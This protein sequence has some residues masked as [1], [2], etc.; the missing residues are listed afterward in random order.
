MPQGQP[1]QL[2]QALAQQDN[3]VQDEGSLDPLA[4][5]QD[6]IHALLGAQFAEGDGQNVH[7]LS[8]AM[9]LL[10]G[11]QARLMKGPNAASQG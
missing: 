7:D 11:I 3:A 2:G 9:V 8:K 10:T 4:A 1:P 6:A 5:L